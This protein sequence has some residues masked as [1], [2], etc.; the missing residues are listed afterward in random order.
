MVIDLY[1]SPQP[2]DREV[3]CSR[4]DI[5]VEVS[6]DRAEQLMAANDDVAVFGQIAQELELSMREWQRPLSI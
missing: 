1:L 6:P 3:N 2:R 5:G 4:A